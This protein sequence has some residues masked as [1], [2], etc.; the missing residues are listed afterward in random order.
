[1]NVARRKRNLVIPIYGA[2]MCTVEF[3]KGESDT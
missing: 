3:H 1:M 2:C